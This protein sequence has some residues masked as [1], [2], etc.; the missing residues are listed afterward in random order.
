MTDD[1]G[2]DNIFKDYLW[3][4]YCCGRANNTYIPKEVIDGLF[5]ALKLKNMVRLA[6]NQELPDGNDKTPMDDFQHIHYLSQ[7]QLRDEHG[8]RRVRH[9]D[10]TEL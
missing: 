1:M 6:D 5:K 7:K 2:I 3:T 10:G 9:L 8:F 4:A